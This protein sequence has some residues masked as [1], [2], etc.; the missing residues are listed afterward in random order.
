MELVE[1]SSSLSSQIE[2]LT[3]IIIIIRQKLVI[4][5]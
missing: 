5:I 4:A 1:G 2:G 3:V